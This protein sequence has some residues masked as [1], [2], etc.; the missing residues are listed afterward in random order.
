MKGLYTSLFIG[1]AL[2]LMAPVMSFAQDSE[3]VKPDRQGRH[4]V[5]LSVFVAGNI[6]SE[7]HSQ[8]SAERWDDYFF[9]NS[10]GVRTPRPWGTF[11]KLPYLEG[12]YGYRI[13]N[14]LSLDF[15]AK[16]SCETYG[17][18][19]TTEEKAWTENFHNIQFKAGVRFYWIN[20]RLVEIYSG[21]SLGVELWCTNSPFF[22]GRYYDAE[23]TPEEVLNPKYKTEAFSMADI[24]LLGVSIGKESGLYGKI[25]AGYCGGA[26]ASIGLGYRF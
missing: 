20:R 12:R 22:G 5:E 19:W 8:V 14:W 13:L 9:H 17:L 21:L 18:Y 15:T 16:Y 6:M 4:E 26:Y 3:Y 23:P 2:F 7:S 25:D 1:V 11:V 10:W 24:K